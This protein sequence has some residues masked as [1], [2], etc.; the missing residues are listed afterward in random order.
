[1]R[2][3]VNEEVDS[4]EFADRFIAELRRAAEAIAADASP[5][6]TERKRVA[7]QIAN[8]LRLTEKAPDSVSLAARLRELEAEQSRLDEQ[9][10]HLAENVEMRAA[11]RKV[12]PEQATAMLAEWIVRDGTTTDEQPAALAQIVERIEFDPSTGEGR[13]IY[14]LPLGTGARFN[15]RKAARQLGLSPSGVCVASPRGFEPR[16]PP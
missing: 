10:A 7:A 8:L 9:L 16:L 3:Q 11:L 5:L 6:K 2:D 14:R 4:H 15:M 13:V 12:S 1:M